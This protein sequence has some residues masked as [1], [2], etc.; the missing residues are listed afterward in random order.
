MTDLNCF[1]LKGKVALVTGA[2]YGIG[3]AIASA[4][5]NAGATR[6]MTQ[7]QREMAWAMLAGRAK[8]VPLFFNRPTDRSFGDNPMNPQ[9]EAYNTMGQRGSSDFASQNVVAVNLFHNAMASEGEKI[10]SINN[11]KVF[12]IE[13][14]S[15]GVVLTNV[16]GSTSISTSTSLP[17]GTYKNQA[18]SGGTFT[19]SNGTLTGNMEGSSI[20]VLYVG[21]DETGGGSTGGSTGGGTVVSGA[22]SAYFVK[23][24]GWGTPN[25]YVYA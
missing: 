16:G 18:A 19:V 14:G 12:K 15:K 22:A 13:R 11:D 17:N 10:S 24:S 2:S 4:Y 20:A 6:G 3:F 21:A 9:G 23:P 8:M 25:A 7:I 1:S 5:A